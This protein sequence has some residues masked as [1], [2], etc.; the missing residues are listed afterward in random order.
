MLSTLSLDVKKLNKNQGT[1]KRLT[2]GLVAL[3]TLTVVAF[4]VM[5]ALFLNLKKTDAPPSPPQPVPP[6]GFLLG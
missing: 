4:G 6:P 1:N 3:L 5:L 2:T